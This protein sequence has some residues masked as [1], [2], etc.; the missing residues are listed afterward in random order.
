M[1]ADSGRAQ[2]VRHVGEEARLLDAHRGQVCRDLGELGVRA[3][4]VRGS[5]DDARLELGVEA[6]VLDREPGAIGEVLEERDVGLA[7]ADPRPAAQDRQR[8]E[9]RAP[10]E[11]RDDGVAVRADAP[12]ELGDLG[13]GGR[14]EDRRIDLAHP[15]P[16]PGAHDGRGDA[17]ARAPRQPHAERVGAVGER[18]VGVAV[19]ARDVRERF[20]V[21]IEE[22]HE[23]AI[24]DHGRDGGRDPGE[25][26]LVVARHACECMRRI[27]QD[28]KSLGNRPTAIHT[29]RGRMVARSMEPAV[30]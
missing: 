14:H 21:G 22:R 15:A 24:A 27:R 12:D 11:D 18:E 7:V 20:A 13:I 5:T 4:Q 3:L 9:H 28:A 17:R 1:I 23:T 10:G 19:C 25:Q 16:L 26:L 30:A 6:R 29:I 8:P 2:L